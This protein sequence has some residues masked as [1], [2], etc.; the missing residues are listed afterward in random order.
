MKGIF[1]LEGGVYCLRGGLQ[2]GLLFTGPFIIMKG[3]FRLEGVIVFFCLGGGGW[4]GI[5]YRKGLVENLSGPQENMFSLFRKPQ[6][7]S[8]EKSKIAPRT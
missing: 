3:T 7:N 5:F 6:L 4:V 2:G 1:S 8:R